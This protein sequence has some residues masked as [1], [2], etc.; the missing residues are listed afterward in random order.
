ME[1]LLLDE[2]GQCH[3]SRGAGYLQYVVW[4]I[5]HQYTGESF[6]SVS[7]QVARLVAVG[8]EKWKTVTFKPI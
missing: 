7:K 3:I 2:P 1:R 4:L 6:V 5:A 8:E